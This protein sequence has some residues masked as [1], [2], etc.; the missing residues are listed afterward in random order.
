MDFFEGRHHN[1]RVREVLSPEGRSPEGDNTSRT[2]QLWCLP[3]K[4][5][6]I[7]LLSWR[8]IQLQ[9]QM[10]SYRFNLTFFRFIEVKLPI[11]TLFFRVRTSSRLCHSIYCSNHVL[12]TI[13]IPKFWMYTNR[14]LSKSSTLRLLS[15][16]FTIQLSVMTSYFLD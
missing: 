1:C 3:S 11:A 5:Y 16:L 15:N 10:N 7:V 12:N 14:T 13:S 8:I 6:I 4:K 2:R 9:E